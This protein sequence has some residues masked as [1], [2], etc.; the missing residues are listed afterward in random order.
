[1]VKAIIGRKIRM[2]QLF[3]A[4]GRRV[5]LTAIQAGPCPIIQ[6]KTPEND[7]YSAIQVGYDEDQRKHGIPQPKIGHFKKSKVKPTRILKEFRAETLDGYELG[8]ELTVA[9]FEPGDHVDV[10]GI[11][12]G[13]G[14]AG[15][16]RRHNFHGG[17]D[18]H[19]S[20]FHRKPGAIGA[21]AYPSRVFK[22]LKLP[23]HMGAKTAIVQNIE[24]FHVDAENHLI[25]V[26]GAIPGPSGG[27]V[28]IK[29]TTKAQKQAKAK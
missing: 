27:V 9:S 16:F 26:R 7:G 8:Q 20:M 25:Y 18:T 14:F 11:S 17:R 21:A 13:R 10:T 15:V 4:S 6:I 24:V 3:E 1:M 29:M 19:G 23:G 5:P 28:S 2:T 22:G 12:K